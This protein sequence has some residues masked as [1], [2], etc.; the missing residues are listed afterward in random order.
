MKK[1]LLCT[2][3]CFSA[4]LLFAQIDY[5][6]ESSTTNEQDIDQIFQHLDK[7]GVTTGVLYDRSAAVTSLYK[8][9]ELNPDT[10]YYQLH[11]Q[12]YSELY[13][14][15]YSNTGLLNPE[16]M[17]KVAEYNFSN[18]L[19]PMGVINYQYNVLDTNATQDNLIY[20][21]G[22][23]LYDVTGRSRVPWWGRQTTMISPLVIETT[24]LAADYYFGAEFWLQ[25]GSKTIKTLQVDFGD[26]SGYQTVTVGAT[27]SVS[28]A[29]SGFKYIKSLITYSDESTLTTYS[30]LKVNGSSQILQRG[31]VSP[32]ANCSM[33]D[34]L[35]KIITTETFQGYTETSARSGVGDVTVF[36]HT[37][38]GCDEVIRKPVIVVDGFDPGS[39]RDASGIYGEL[40][41]NDGANNMGDDLRAQGY[42]VI[43]LDFPKYE[44]S[45]TSFT[46]FGRILTYSNFLDGG[47]DYIERNALVLKQLIR[48]VN[49]HLQQINST[50]QL[51]VV[52]PSMGGL[53]ARYALAKMEQASES[54]NTRLF[55]SFDS[56]HTGANIP[57]GDQLYL[58]FYARRDIES[59][60]ISRDEK[61][62][63]TAA[64]QMLRVHYLSRQGF[65]PSADFGAPGFRNRFQTE[66]DNTG[67]PQ[68]LRKVAVVNGRI[69]GGMDF[70]SC[71]TALRS[72]TIITIKK[73]LQFSPVSGGTVKF[74][75]ASGTGL[76][77]V[78]D[79]KYIFKHSYLKM[80]TTNPSITNIDTAPGGLYDTQDIIRTEG[81]GFSKLNRHFYSYTY[82]PILIPTHS[83]IP[84]V[85]GLALTNGFTRNLT[86]V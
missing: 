12:A 15:T 37:N 66:L 83:F 18:N 29:S 85:S 59:A 50:E 43:V 42:D 53:I 57:L 20:E 22:E 27:V 44:T 86:M 34:E 81:G 77:T 21:S 1:L 75:P 64:K 28:Y 11:L 65:F 7:T 71:Q 16:V 63:S 38:S 80:S 74:M 54:H 40:R 6:Q 56:P 23:L 35:P 9:N 14:A 19:I 79:A 26:G 47:S 69:D 82:F 36:Y 32:M 76:C 24:Q 46:F 5:Q 68:N 78:F 84:T 70:S 72:H 41:Y 17:Q 3:L 8:F 2:M 25:N 30:A 48:N 55:V 51:I 52:G 60:K 49:L 13:H 33:V 39:V 10:S 67:W 31:S 45:T 73:H 58:D 4:S 61:L 62:A